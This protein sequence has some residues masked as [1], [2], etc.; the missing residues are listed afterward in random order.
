MGGAQQQH[1]DEGGDQV[2]RHHRGRQQPGDG[3]R[4]ECALESYQEQGCEGSRGQPAGQA[5]TEPKAEGAE[6]EQGHAHQESV[7]TVKPFQEHLNVHLTTG[8]QNPVTE[9]PVR[10]GQ[11][12][13]HDP[14]GTADRHP[15]H[16]GDHEVG[17]EELKCPGQSEGKGGNRG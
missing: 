6:H 13:L 15:G 9:R 2:G 12:R 17:G 3:E 16:Q 11:T 1:K 14:G 5:G 7:Q 8:Q 4:T 10:T